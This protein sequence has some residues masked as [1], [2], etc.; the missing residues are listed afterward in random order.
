MKNKGKK[1]TVILKALWIYFTLLWGYIAVENLV[2]PSV[3]YS[4]DFSA[5]VPIRADLLGIISFALSF[6]FYV[7][8]KLQEN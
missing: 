6:V 8:W 1:S 5:Y 7:V 3:V 4:T 2:Y